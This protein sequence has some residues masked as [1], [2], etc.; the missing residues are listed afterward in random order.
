M[1]ETLAALYGAIIDAPTDRTVRLVYADALDESG[2][3][4]NTARAEFIRGQVALEAM[5][6][7]DP[8]QAALAARCSELFAENWLDW[9]RPVCAAVGLPEPFVPTRRLRERVKRLVGREKREPGAPYKAH[10]QAWSI[11]SEEHGFTAQ[12]IAGFPELLYVHRFTIDTITG[13][14]GTWLGGAPFG[15]LRFAEDVSQFEWESLNGPHLAKLCELNFDRLSEGTAALAARSEPLR[16]LTA[17]KVLPLNSAA[18]V[19]RVLVSRPAWAGLR[20]LT[21]SGVTPPDAIQMLAERCT[22]EELETLSFGIREVPDLPNLGGLSGA[23]GFMFNEIFSRFFGE[24]PMPPGP[25]RWP[26]YWPAML[27]LAHSPVLPRLRTLQITDAGTQLNHPNEIL[28][29]LM[30][31]GENPSPAADPDVLFP[32]TLVGALAA[33]LNADRLVRL[34]LPAARVAPA[35]RAELTRRFGTRLVLA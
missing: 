22:L 17:L 7:G 18:D 16:N 21:L 9:W 32:D 15:R 25:I 34:E 31:P 23:L 2:E 24:Q 5:P 35:G 29:R 28:R 3:P 27:A 6:A 11:Q 8:Q 20:S 14:V 13:Q 26:D 33:G 1:T 30:H 12:F 10:P 4:S 19:V